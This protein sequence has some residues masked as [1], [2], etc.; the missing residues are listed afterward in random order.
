M[1]RKD[2]IVT[3]LEERC[4]DTAA[5][6]SNA[7]DDDIVERMKKIIMT[8]A[9]I[10]ESLLYKRTLN[11]YSIYKNGS[12]I[13]EK[14]E[15]LRKKLGG[16]V[17]VD[18]DGEIVYHRDGDN[19]YFRPTPLSSVR[20][21]YQIPSSEAANAVLYILETGTK[22][23]YTKSEL[24]RLFLSEMGYLKSGDR[25]DELFNAAISDGRIKRSGNGRI[26]K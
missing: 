6:L 12:R 1:D 7:I 3:E 15:G 19:T 10:R 17:S 11:S 14:L 5:F 8:E 18:Y 21:S 16:N 22:A 23:S 2:Y 4:M 24:F 25:L 20:Y 13:N 26:L 9:P